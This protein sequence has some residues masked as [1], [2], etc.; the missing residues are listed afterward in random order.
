MGERG[1]EIGVPE[2]VGR[3][4]E[5][6]EAVL[7]EPAG[8]TISART[9][10]VAVFLIAIAAGG[11]LFWRHGLRNTSG[12]T[13]PGLEPARP[14]RVAAAGPATNPEPSS[15]ASTGLV[16]ATVLGPKS[17][18]DFKIGAITL[19]KA[20]GS[21]LIYAL[22]TLR[23]ESEHQRFGVKLEFELMDAR[24]AVIGAAKDYRAVI[25]PRQ[26]WRFRALV[27]DA[28]AVTARVSSIREDE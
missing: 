1:P 26:E 19:E 11:G 18:D 12:V 8:R 3:A 4:P 28:K 24:G 16:T 27:L 5:P 10:L 6:V 22:G 13:G 17:T 2:I 21:S 23:N 20:K 9:W 15:T 14:R 7:P 25:E